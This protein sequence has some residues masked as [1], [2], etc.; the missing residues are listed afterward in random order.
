MDSIWALRSAYNEARKVKEAQDV[1]C[2]KAEAGLWESL[3]GHLP[4]NPQWE[5]LVDVL[6]G[7]VKVFILYSS[8]TWS[9]N[10]Y[11]IRSRLIVMKLSISTTWF[12][13]VFLLGKIDSYCLF[14]LPFHS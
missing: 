13:Y 14:D 8:H 2:S 9:L 12:A 6:R 5:M 4:Q 11:S 10:S 1:Y 3:E 7:R